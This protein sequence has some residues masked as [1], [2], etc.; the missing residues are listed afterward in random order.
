MAISRITA[1]ERVGL[2]FLLVI[3]FQYDEG[4]R[5]ME[6]SLGLGTTKKL[7]KFLQLFESLL[8]FDAWANKNEY[9][10]VDDPIQCSVRSDSI[11]RMMHHCKQLIRNVKKKSKI[12]DFPF[13]CPKFHEILHLL[14]DI[15]RFG[16]PMNFCAQR[17]ESLLIPAAKQPG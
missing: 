8:R 17:P 11:R 15:K 3:L 10:D 2:V 7:P 6:E 9:S 13:R 4:W 14:D 12:I 1:S 5:I 16:A